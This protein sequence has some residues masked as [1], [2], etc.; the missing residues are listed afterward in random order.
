MLRKI[1]IKYLVVLYGFIF[2]IV[3]WKMCKIVFVNFFVNINLLLGVGGS[4]FLSI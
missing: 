3:F 1:V 2:E 4:I